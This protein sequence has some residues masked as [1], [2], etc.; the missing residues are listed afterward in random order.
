MVS[1]RMLKLWGASVLPPLELIFKFCFES[2][3][4]TSEWKKA[5]VLLVHKTCDKQS[6][7]NYRAIS[8]LPVCGKT[9]DWYTTKCLSENDLISHD[10]SEFYPGDSCINYLLSITNEIYKPFDEGNETKAVI[11]DISTAFDKVWKV[12]FWKVSFIN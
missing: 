7:K 10:Q 12:S 5:N 11:L 1:I 8:L 6:L 3:K 2:G 9:F 4:F